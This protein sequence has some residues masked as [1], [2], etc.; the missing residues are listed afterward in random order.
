MCG[1]PM[2]GH[3]ITKC[4]FCG[5]TQVVPMP[6]A[7]EIASFYHEDLD[8][9]APYIEQIEVHREYFRKTLQTVI[10]AKA[11]IRVSSTKPK[12]I[13]DQVGNDRRLLDIGCAMGVFLEEAKKIGFRVQGTDV[14]A[15]AVA[16]CRKKGLR[17][18]RP[19]LERGPFDVIT[20]F[21]VI[22]HERDPLGMMQR[23]Y[24]LLKKNGIGVLTTPNHASIWRTLMGKWW[25]GYHHPEHVTFWDTGSL[26]FLMKKAGF[27]NIVIRRDTP[28][29]FPL[30][31]AF[32]RG[33]DY[34]PWAGQLLRPIGKFLDHWHVKNPVNPWD[35]LLA[36]GRK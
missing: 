6:T 31:F 11:G 2:N 20:A 29:P 26:T 5:L 7:R 34:L 19:G 30:S 12:P 25:V 35:D 13:P 14:S 23:I 8:H 32:T 10:P 36:L 22:E 4:T 18:T 17:V 9:F 28:R 24:S 21:E 27:K 3:G 33:A 1:N 16:Y 15:D